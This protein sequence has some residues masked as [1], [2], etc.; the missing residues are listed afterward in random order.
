L[1]AAFDSRRARITADSSGILPEEVVVIETSGPVPDF[2]NAVR[3]IQGM[4]WLGEVDEEEIPPDDDFFALDTAGNRTPGVLRGRL[5]MIF[6]NQA[7]LHQLLSLW[8]RWKV[9]Q[10]LGRGF[11]K[12]RDVFGLLRDIRPWGV[13]DRLLE[14]GAL[15]DWNDRARH[16][17]TNVPIE[18][19][20]WFRSDPAVRQAA[21]DRVAL[22]LRELGGSVSAE[23]VI[24]EIRYH[25]IAARVSMAA[26]QRMATQETE[27]VRC[28]Q[29]QFFRAAGQ[30]V[31]GLAEGERVGGNPPQAEPTAGRSL[32][33]VALLDGMPLQAHRRLV[34]HLVLDDPDEIE[35]HYQAAERRHGT[36]MA[37]LIIHGD[38]AG[39]PETVVSPIYV[40]P[41]LR[42]DPRDWRAPR[43][44]AVPEDVLIVDLLH[45]SV[46]RMI[47][48][49]GTQPAAAPSVRI[50]NLSIGIRD[51]PFE[52][53]LSPLARL[54][55]WLAW[56]YDLLFVVSAGN[57]VQAL[58][59]GVSAAEF[60]DLDDD[61]KC[62]EIV[63]SLAADA[64]HRR[65]L[66]PAESVNALTVAA[67]HRDHTIEAIPEDAIEPFNGAPLPSTINAQ[68][69]GY[70]RSVKPELLA[71]GG[72]LILRKVP[73]Q[74]EQV[75]LEMVAGRRP[76]GQRVAAPG[77]PGRLDAEWY[78]CG[79]SNA[80]AMTCRGAALLNDVVEGLRR[81]P[82]GGLIDSVPRGVWLKALV[83]H[84]AAWGE[85]GAALQRYLRTEEN[86]RQF[87]E[88]VC[89]LL[90]YGEYDI[91]RVRECTDKR[92]TVLTGG[93]LAAEAA[94]VHRFPLPP[95]LSGQRGLRRLTITLA[96]ITP[97]N[98]A[99][100]SWRR[101]QL[102]FVPPGDPLNVTR[103]QA[104]WRA[105]QRG[106]LQHE[107]LEGTE[108]RS[109]VDGDELVVT[110]NCRAEAGTLEE[111]V[112][113][114]MALTLEVGDEIQIAIYDEIRS[115]IRAKIRVAPA[116]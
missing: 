74:A 34:G 42:P 53:A 111:D 90:G 5:F 2:L 12:F 27:L 16:Q 69:L 13:K 14:T 8:D 99:H 6:S 47:E 45:R 29:I 23:S 97:V 107:V 31:A 10:D 67:S 65:L 109:F 115:R 32:P 78:C 103:Q 61:A 105:V 83:A 66:S 71:P 108:A 40:R 22:L 57:C 110:V 19:E 93:S 52:G 95:S 3:R 92:V 38:L 36:A 46:L 4:E 73:G 70:R 21:R 41:I 20:L 101:A 44:E 43:D 17:A 26:A 84:G 102:W 86:A 50:V 51:R 55:D 54:I 72:K 87:K 30:M 18:I 76:P 106:T 82:G 35:S 104:D 116:S 37:S 28:E 59:L 112:P 62:K 11:A 89:R 85:A 68:G 80:A 24:S 56:R 15:E 64:R 88:Y 25:G 77:A 79:T 114:A 94:H 98:P 49:D 39:T 96:W 60:D 63:K 113:Y 100:E 58:T 81:E 9:G 1:Q 33:I 7:A 48:S 91:E 75:V